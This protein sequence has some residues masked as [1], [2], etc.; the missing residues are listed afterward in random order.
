[1]CNELEARTGEQVLGTSRCSHVAQKSLEIR[2][3][4]S[5]S[6]PYETLALASVKSHHL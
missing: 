1:M 6:V 4:D 5:K 2:R 3:H